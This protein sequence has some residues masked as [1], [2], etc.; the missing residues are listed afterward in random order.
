MGPKA[1]FPGE[2]EEP[3]EA[4]RPNLGASDT[5]CRA[6]VQA[7]GPNP[8]PWDEP[9]VACVDNVAVT[10]PT[11]Q[12]RLQRNTLVYSR[13]QRRWKSYSSCAHA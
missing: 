12:V 3:G 2:V 13:R 8:H 9:A 1:L 7:H 11:A 4:L 10:G 5:N 6:R